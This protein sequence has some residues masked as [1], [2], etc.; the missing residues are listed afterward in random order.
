MF[1]GNLLSGWFASWFALLKGSVISSA[2]ARAVFKLGRFDPVW[3]RTFEM[4]F[5]FFKHRFEDHSRH[6]RWQAGVFGK[7]SNGLGFFN[8]AVFAVEN[9]PAQKPDFNALFATY[10]W[11]FDIHSG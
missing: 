2:G 4:S 5:G 9:G 10:F 11:L 1:R 7:F 6:K 3:I 8:Q